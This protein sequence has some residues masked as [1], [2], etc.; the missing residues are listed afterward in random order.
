MFFFFFKVCRLFV[1]TK[2]SVH[3]PILN[4]IKEKNKSP[5]IT[6]T[7]N[8]TQEN[9]SNLNLKNKKFNDSNKTT[10]FH[11]RNSS[12]PTLLMSSTNQIE[13]H[14]KNNFSFFDK[15][16]KKAIYLEK[17]QQSNLGS[18][19]TRN[20]NL[21]NFDFTNTE[22]TEFHSKSKIKNIGLKK[23][24]ETLGEKLGKKYIR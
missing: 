3:N 21:S 1:P 15:H 24:Q 23:L 9:E 6:I 20:K 16:N 14:S 19:T 8:N 13:T 11:S 5:K 22:S 12:L 17:L 7:I 18:F 2:L 4:L 10:N